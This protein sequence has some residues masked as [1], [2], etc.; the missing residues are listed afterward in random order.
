MDE[1]TR[2]KGGGAGGAGGRRGG[3]PLAVRTAYLLSQLGRIQATG[4]A[5]RLQPLGLRP[6][7]FAL[8]NIVALDEGRSQQEL[9]QQ[10]ALEPSGV[11]RTIDELEQ[12]GLLER[13]RDSADR[14]RYAVHLTPAGRTV[15][16]DARRAAAERAAMLFEPLDA[17]ELDALHDMLARI[18]VAAEPTMRPLG[19]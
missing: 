12:Q 17:E 10:L 4:L 11:V 14:R 7:H 9:G 8:L 6:R 16:S 5:E 3:P 15:L 2:A 18:A 1:R 19:G 13:R